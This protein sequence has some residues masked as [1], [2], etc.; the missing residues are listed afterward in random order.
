MAPPMNSNATMNQR[1][2]ANMAGSSLAPASVGRSPEKMRFVSSPGRMSRDRRGRAGGRF[3]SGRGRP[4]GIAHQDLL[5]SARDFRME[6]HRRLRQV[7]ERPVLER[8]VTVDVDAADER[9][10][11]VGADDL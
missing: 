1:R 10:A 5:M 9:R 2:R 4:S 6:R 11:V 3:A 7:R 8:E